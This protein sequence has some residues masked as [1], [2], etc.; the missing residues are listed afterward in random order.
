VAA[1]TGLLMVPSLAFTGS[2]PARAVVPSAIPASPTWKDEFTSLNASNW[3]GRGLDQVIGTRRCGLPVAAN[4]KI[5]G[6]KYTATVAKASKKEKAQILASQKTV[7]GKSVG[8]KYGYFTNASLST[9]KS[10][11]VHGYGKVETKVKFPVSQGMHFAVWLQSTSGP[12]IDLIE[13]FGYGKGITNYVHVKNANGTTTRYPHPTKTNYVLASATKKKS[14]WGKYHTYS[15]EW[16]PAATP[17]FA[18]Y[19]FK[20]D[21]KVTYQADIATTMADYF[22][23]MSSTTSDWELRYLKK[24][25]KGKAKGVKKATFPSKMYVDY[26]RVWQ[27][28]G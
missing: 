9:Y 15:V 5:S 27:W 12:E 8:C 20:A 26:V 6:G 7:L 24:P 22:L 14:W 16:T 23:V 10:F 25:S 4:S 2:A 17:G 11:L 19:V 13:S 1:A 28:Q 21:G 18:H 3:S